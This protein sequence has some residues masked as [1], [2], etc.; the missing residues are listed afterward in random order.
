M[1]QNE[2]VRVEHLTHRLRLTRKL[3]VPAVSDVSFGIRQ[4][5]ILGI[6]G[7]SGSGK[8]TV[9]RCLMGILQPAAGRI[10]VEDIDI[11]AA[12]IPKADRQRLQRER[13]IIFQ[14]SASSLNPRMSVRRILS[15]PLCIHGVARGKAER[16]RQLV[17][18]LGYVGLDAGILDAR[19]SELSGGQRQ[20]VSIAR[21]L[22]MEPKLLI[23]DEPIAS[24]DVSIQA[25]IVN[26]FRH[27]QRE[28]GFTFLFIAHDL[29][30]VEFLCDRVGV[31]T[32]GRLVELAPTRA[33]YDHP[34]H[35]Y[36]RALLA[37][38]PIPDPRIERER[39]IAVWREPESVAHREWTQVEP[40]HFVLLEQSHD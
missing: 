25:Q 39:E 18:N 21:A 23:A 36:T 28:H 20:R 30:M 8:S 2:L 24:L 40:E 3:F 29:A 4:G 11:T 15:E 13:Q 5:E 33:L 1:P 7:E 27:L 10:W 32:R 12:R 14:D 22:L 9:A 38:M 17:Q 26:L 6:V 37:S 16:E 31:M 34:L 35:P 19:P